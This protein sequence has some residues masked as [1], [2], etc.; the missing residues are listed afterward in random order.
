V[1][2]EH[3]LAYLASKANSAYMQLEAAESW[4]KD[5]DT[6]RKAHGEAKAAAE[7]LLELA[8]ERRDSPDYAAAVMT[9]HQTLGL[10]ALHDGDQDRAVD[11]M[12]ESV[13]V[14]ELG[15]DGGIVERH[16]LAQRLPIYLLKEGERETVIEYYEAAAKI[17]ARERER[18]LEDARAVREGRMPRSYQSMFAHPIFTAQ[19]APSGAFQR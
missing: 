9:A 18:L 19:P 4:R 10:I 8:E 15:P 2:D 13:K 7:A 16:F 3:R 11:H 6:A 12:L 14:P 5:E 17:N 1:P